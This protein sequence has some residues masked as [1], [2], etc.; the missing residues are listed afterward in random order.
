MRTLVVSFLFI[1][2]F[3]FAQASDNYFSNF[4]ISGDFL[5]MNDSNSEPQ[6]IDFKDHFTFGFFFLIITG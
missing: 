2:S 3:A 6:I 4:F 5:I 1:S